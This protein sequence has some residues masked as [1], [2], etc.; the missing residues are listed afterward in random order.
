MEEKVM[1]GQNDYTSFQEFADM[2][3]CSVKEVSAAW[4]LIISD[5]A[6]GSNIDCSVPG[7]VSVYSLSK[8]HK[9]LK[10]AQNVVVYGYYTDDVGHILKKKSL[11]A[12]LESEKEAVDISCA[13][14]SKAFE[15]I[16]AEEVKEL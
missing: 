5:A 11:K 14:I 7:S 15:V 16:T 9:A 10:E 13:D 2:Y 1:S 4:D 3:G 6:V 8:V 12:Q